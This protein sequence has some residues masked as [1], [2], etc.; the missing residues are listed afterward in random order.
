MQVYCQGGICLILRTYNG[1]NSLQFAL[2][3]RFMSQIEA[4][5][6]VF[7]TLEILYTIV[8]SI[9]RGVISPILRFHWKNDG[10]FR[11]YSISGTNRGNGSFRGFGYSLS[12]ADRG[13]GRSA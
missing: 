6:P 12:E 5:Q 10:H 11:S 8:D 2:V 3:L 7:A 13:P 1:D 4:L 9:A